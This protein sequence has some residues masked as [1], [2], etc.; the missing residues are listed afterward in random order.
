MLYTVDFPV[1]GWT[2]D[3][4]VYFLFVLY[5][6]VTALSAFASL[7]ITNRLLSIFSCQL[8]AV[9]SVGIAINCYIFYRGGVDLAVFLSLSSVILNAIYIVTFTRM[10][11][12]DGLLRV[13][14]WANRAGRV[15]SLLTL[16]LLAGFTHD[17]GLW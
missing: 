13:V 12:V 9:I 8:H 11:R 1:F 5:F 10:G 3:H 14:I 16:L 2:L 7:K 6:A 15:G 17:I 4:I